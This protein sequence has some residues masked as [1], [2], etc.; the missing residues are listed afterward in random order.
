M[1]KEILY[2]ITRKSVKE[3]AKGSGF[4]ETELKNLNLD[5]FYAFH[6]CDRDLIEPVSS[7]SL[8]DITDLFRKYS[9]T[10]YLRL[11][12][13]G[14]FV[15]PYS[16]NFNED[17]YSLDLYQIDGNLIS[18]ADFIKPVYKHIVTLGDNTNPQ[19]IRDLMEYKNNGMKQRLE[20]VVN[21][22]IDE[23]RK[24]PQWYE[25]Y[26]EKQAWKRMR[27]KIEEKKKIIS[28]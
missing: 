24:H 4:S 14:D 12:E 1:V 8:E 15:K 25:N 13:L 16:D 21:G 18:V 2:E 22:F 26:R 6:K 19:L 11:A 3:F 10:P 23:A 27:R 5:L 17:L 28:S 9:A 20:E 7:K